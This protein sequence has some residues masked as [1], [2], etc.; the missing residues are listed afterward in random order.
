[1]RLALILA[2]LYN[3]SWGALVVLFPLA[4][5]RWAG[6]ASPNYPQIWQCLGMVVGVYGV[7]YLIAAT[8][9]A[10]HW[11]VVFVGLLGKILGPI[12]MVWSLAQA[13]LPHAAALLCV[14][15]DLIWWLP[16]GL[17]LWWVYRSENGGEM[18][19]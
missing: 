7:A 11:A 16:F 12:G 15:N 19:T 18:R 8:A 9:P 3:L 13:T 2:G 5:F 17:I 1:M 10:R 6:M 14:F 4:P